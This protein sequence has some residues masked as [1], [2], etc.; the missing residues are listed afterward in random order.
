MGWKIDDYLESL[1]I[2][3]ALITSAG[4]GTRFLPISKTIQKEMLPVLTR[5]IIDYIVSD[6]V[7]AGIEEIII[8]VKEGE[9]RLVEHFYMEHK[10][11]EQHLTQMG[12]LEKFHDK[13][14]QYDNIKFTFVP[15]TVD[16]NYGTAIPV[17]LAKKHLENE[18]AFL[19]FMGDDFIY[20][21]N[22]KSEAKA[23][24]EMFEKSG[25][26][27]LVTCITKPDEELYRY[28]VAEV[29]KENGFTYL[30]NLVEKPEAGKAPSNLTN[31]SKYILTPDI[32]EIIENQKPNEANGEFY[33]TDSVSELAKSSDVCI[34]TP[35]GRYL[36][37][38]NLINWLKANIVVAKSDPDLAE[39]L[40]QFVKAE[41]EL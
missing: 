4:F 37:G 15:Q 32:F 41:F 6:C 21:Q 19:V 23:M 12:K 11:L 3:K 36:D 31:I 8:V 10:S 18:A 27:G 20:N 28:G 26:K 30:K 29:L 25:S 38:G 22:G 14:H 17:K 34:Y 35:S 40:K 2:K 33:I 7:A 16:D 5:P 24:M 39:E 1:M 9:N 13:I